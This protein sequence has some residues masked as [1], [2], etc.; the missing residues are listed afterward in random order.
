M[1]TGQRLAAGRD[2][3]AELADGLHLPRVRIGLPGRAWLVPGRRRRV[4]VI[5]LGAALTVLV[6]VVVVT[7]VLLETGR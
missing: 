4:L 3:N 1:V 7:T 2:G 6:H 5:S